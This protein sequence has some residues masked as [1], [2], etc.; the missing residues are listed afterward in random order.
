MLEYSD[1]E[2]IVLYCDHATSGQFHSKI[3][4]DLDLEPLPS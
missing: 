2:I 3:K 4:S 1:Q